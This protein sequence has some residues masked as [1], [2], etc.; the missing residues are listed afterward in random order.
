MPGS[1]ASDGQP[2]AGGSGVLPVYDRSLYEGPTLGLL[3]IPNLALFWVL[4]ASGLVVALQLCPARMWLTVRASVVL[5]A[6]GEAVY[7]VVSLRPTSTADAVFVTAA[8]AGCNLAVGLGASL[9][10]GRNTKPCSHH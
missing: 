6:A 4:E 10:A 9:A 3:A 2:M 1:R 7:W 5:A 8:L